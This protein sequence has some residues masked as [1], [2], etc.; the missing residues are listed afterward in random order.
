MIDRRIPFP[1]TIKLSI[2]L[3]SRAVFSLSSS[4]N[5]YTN[6]KRWYFVLHAA[7]CVIISPFFSLFSFTICTTPFSHLS[8]TSHCFLQ[9][10]HGGASQHFC[11]FGH[12]TTISLD[13]F[14]C[15][16]LALSVMA[17]Q[18]GFYSAADLYVSISLSPLHTLPYVSLLCLSVFKCEM[19]Q[20]K[21]WEVCSV[22]FPDLGIFITLQMDTMFKIV[23]SI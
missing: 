22:Q 4:S 19:A 15:S 18:D 23:S 12:S 3:S 21:P 9:R 10:P 17:Y 5:Q 7:R 13:S 6:T 1:C 8:Q 11:S 20:G 16:S 14:P 2:I